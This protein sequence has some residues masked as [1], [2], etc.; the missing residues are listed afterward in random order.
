MN[1]INKPI[2][3]YSNQNFR[4]ENIKMSDDKIA[5]KKNNTLALSLAGVG[6][7]G[8]ITTAAGIL[9][10]KTRAQALVKAGLELKDGLVYVKETG[11]KFT[12]TI[13]RNVSAFGFKKEITNIENG[14]L[15][16][17][18]NYGLM[19][20]ELKGYFFKDG[21]L[22]YQTTTPKGNSKRKYYACYKYEKGKLQ[23][24]SDCVTE[25]KQSVFELMCERVKHIVVQ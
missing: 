6:V 10:K 22:L 17:I 25:P 4:G 14:M 8:I 1:T 3:I 13:K 15:K 2:K 19:G 18:L 23:S 21:N 12:G 20:K 7:L 24:I 16:E 5:P 9:S 11:E